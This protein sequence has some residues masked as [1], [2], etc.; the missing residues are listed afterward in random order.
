MEKYRLRLFD[1]ETSSQLSTET[2][3]QSLPRIGDTLS[4]SS[5]QG[6]NNTPRDYQVEKVIRR[7][8]LERDALNHHIPVIIARTT[9]YFSQITVAESDEITNHI[10]L[11]LKNH[12]KFFLHFTEFSGKRASFLRRSVF[13]RKRGAERN[14]NPGNSKV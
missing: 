4:Y 13:E 11:T 9:N 2:E 7:V 10:Q 14:E 8:D 1:R 12:T 5:D 3:S 6:V